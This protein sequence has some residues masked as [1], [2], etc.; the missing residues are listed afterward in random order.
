MRLYLIYVSLKIVFIDGKMKN[1]IYKRT[2]FKW[3]Y[4]FGS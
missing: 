1:V 4:I 2:I 3:T